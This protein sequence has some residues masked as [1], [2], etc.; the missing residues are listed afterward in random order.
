MLGRTSCHCYSGLWEPWCRCPAHRH[1]WWLKRWWHTVSLHIP[2]SPFAVKSPSTTCIVLVILLLFRFAG[3]WHSSQLLNWWSLPCPSPATTGTLR[4]P[5]SHS[6]TWVLASCCGVMC[7][8]FSSPK[9]LVEAMADSAGEHYAHS[10]RLQCPPI[11]LSP[12]VYQTLW[13]VAHWGDGV[14]GLIRQQ[15][16]FGDGGWWLTSNKIV[17][18]QF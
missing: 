3:I 11:L 15:R 16:W 13:A 1:L 4:E 17:F 10:P 5:R 9:E 7:A 18:F 2:Q 8:N 12:Q 14:G 6:S